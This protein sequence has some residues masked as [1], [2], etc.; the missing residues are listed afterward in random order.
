MEYIEHGDLAQ[1]ID[2]HHPQAVAEVKEITKQI[3]NGLV[4]MHSRGI[5]HRDL[6]PQVRSRYPPPPLPTNHTD[7]PGEYS[8]QVYLT[9]LGENHR[10]R[11]LETERGN[12]VKNSLRHILLP[13]SGGAWVTAL[14]YENMGEFLYQRCRFMGIGR[15]GAQDSDNRNPISRRGP[16]GVERSHIWLRFRIDD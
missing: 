4:V 8:S 9:Y 7:S 13:G 12:V 2:K 16:R 3:L 6:K 10:F 14:E 15:G 11:N 1:Y 5:C